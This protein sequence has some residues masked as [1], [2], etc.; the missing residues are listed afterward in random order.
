MKTHY[1]KPKKKNKL[2][3]EIKIQMMIVH[4]YIN[5]KEENKKRIIFKWHR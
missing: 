3:K 2:E 5:M 1:K 4:K